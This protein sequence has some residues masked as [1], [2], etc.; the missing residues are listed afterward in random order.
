MSERSTSV[1]EPKAVTSRRTF[2]KVLGAAS[3][4][5][6]A[7]GCSSNTGEELIPVSR[8][9]RRDG[10]GRLQL[11]RV[12]LPRVRS[13]LR[14]PSRGARRAH[15]QGRGESGS[16]AESRRALLAR[17]GGGAGTLQSGSLPPADAPQE[18]RARADLVDAG[19]HAAVAAARVTCRVRGKAGT[20]SSSTSTRPEAF[21]AFSMR[22]SPASACPR[23]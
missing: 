18:R 14:R 9:P 17:T 11:L 8:A 21:P 19:D 13:R 12:D 7:I 5:T 2:L 20:R 22:G 4:T 15:L 10:A 3:A 1:D 16:S 23:T 6:A